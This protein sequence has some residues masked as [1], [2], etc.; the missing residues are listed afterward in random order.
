M[1][2]DSLT[3][4]PPV[5]MASSIF[6][7]PASLRFTHV[8]LLLTL[9]FISCPSGNA[10]DVACE[11]IP[12]GQEFWIRLTDPVSTYSSK[13]GSS[14][15]AILIESPRCHEVPALSTGLVVEGRITYLRRVGMGVLHES[16]AVTIDF[17]RVFAGPEPLPI[18]TRVEEV[19]NGREDVKKGVIQGVSERKTPQQIMTTWL[20]H[21]P[22]CDAGGY[23]MFLLRPAI[24]PYSPEPEIS[25]P[26]GTDL[27]LR[28]TSPLTLP[29]DWPAVP[30]QTSADDAAIDARVSEAL[31]A[32]P[33]RS[34]TRK[35]RPSD[36]VNLAFLGSA[37][38]IDEAFKAAGWTYGDSVSTRSVLR[39]MR[40]LSSLN[41]YAHLPISNQWLGGQ[42]PDFTLQKSFDSYQKREHIRFWNE[43]APGQN[44]WVSGAIRETSA[45]WSI[46]KGKFIHHVD[47]DLDAEREKVVRDLTLTGCVANV[48][49]VQRPQPPR[50]LKISSGDTLRTNGAVAVI[51]LKGCERGPGV[52]N[53]F[54]FL[55]SRPNS[56]LKRFA[57]AQIL[58]IHDLWR[59]NMI[60]ESF[61]VSRML[62]RSWH[63]RSVENRRVREFEAQQG[64]TL[65]EPVASGAN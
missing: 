30:A 31:E 17:D 54:S 21:F 63:S 45:A 27:R 55:P 3:A 22:F 12:A 4:R 8:I 5:G 61:D 40:A 57:R 7:C 62:I 42:A 56:R 59:S 24:F 34:A 10:Q 53:T 47:P 43:S 14:V 9:G 35:G 51:Q 18:K 2:R 36:V 38:Q 29:S 50:Q 39:E 19:A 32:L 49:N 37:Q 58:F 46:R 41:S 48:Y 26:P 11:T 64:N 16:S 25:L 13:R 20:L 44:L 33:E 28:L 65:F 15:R 6:P 1:M 52:F 60:Y 23:W